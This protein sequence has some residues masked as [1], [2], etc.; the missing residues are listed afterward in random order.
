[1]YYFDPA[2]AKCTVVLVTA[3]DAVVLVSSKYNVAVVTAKDT[4]QCKI[5]CCCCK[6]RLVKPY[7]I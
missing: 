2:K 1:M 6:K 7:S 5:H 4:T 3:K